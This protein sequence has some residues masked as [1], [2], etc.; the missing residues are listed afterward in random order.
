MRLEHLKNLSTPT[1]ILQGERDALGNRE[2]IGSYGLPSSIEV[3]FLEDGDHS[4]RPRKRSGLTLEANMEKAI[5]EAVRFIDTIK[6][7]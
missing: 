2:E 1:L 5:G 7:V 3:V 4:F 6:V